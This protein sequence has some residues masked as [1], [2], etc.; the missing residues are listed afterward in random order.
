MECISRCNRGISSKA[1]GLG[2]ITE[3]AVNIFERYIILKYDTSSETTIYDAQKFLFSKRSMTPDMCYP[4][5]QLLNNTSAEPLTKENLDG[6]MHHYCC[7]I[8]TLYYK[9]GL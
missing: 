2:Q 8:V 9:L 5:V 4:Q 3:E 1:K 7:T 6:T